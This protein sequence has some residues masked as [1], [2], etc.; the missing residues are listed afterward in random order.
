[1]KPY[2]KYI[3]AFIIGVFGLLTLFLSGTIIFDLVG[4]RAKQG[5]YV[6]FVI[7]TNFVCSFI[8]IAAAYGFIKNKTWTT[9][10]MA[11]S[12][13]LLALT[14]IAFQMHIAS[15]GIHKSDTTGALIFRLSISTIITLVAYFYI[16]KQKKINV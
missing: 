16:T 11:F 13:V 6:P 8:Y 9:K 12:V 3:P 14:F 7:W 4:M 2:I 15:G 10:I 5:N 1:M